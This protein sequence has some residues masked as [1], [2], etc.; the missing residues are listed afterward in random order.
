MTCENSIGSLCTGA[1]QLDVAVRSLLGGTS[2]WHAEVEPNAARVLEHRF[3][4]VPNLGDMTKLTDTPPVRILALG[5][6][7]QP[8]SSA[9][10]Q[11]FDSD[12]RWLWPHALRVITINRPPIVVFENVAGLVTGRKGEPW[13]AILADWRAAGYLIKW[14]LLGA[15]AIGAAHCRHR[16]FA[17]GV[18]VGVDIA[19]DPIRLDVKTCGKRSARYLPS[20][21]AN[22]GK[23][24]VALWKSRDYPQ[25]LRTAV[26]MLPSP[27]AR[28]GRG[29]GSPEYWAERSE[30]TGRTNGV[31]LGAALR[32]LATPRA[33]D[34]TVQPQHWGRYAEAIARQAAWFGEPPAPTEPNRNGAPR[35]RAE[36]AEWLM[37]WPAGWVTDILPRS[38]ALVRI[39]NG[40][41]PQQAIA[42]LRILLSS[43]A[44]AVPRVL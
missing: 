42:A 32:L 22:D 11:G 13:R 24:G 25:D 26:A 3:P 29:E 21:T 44:C 28:D 18:Y 4:G 5:V 43:I 34:G 31:P 15:C 17:L 7:C 30:Q 40:V 36:F 19:P 41:M 33:T 12:S 35:L 8:A 20:P 2:A 14:L 1:G 37:G 6:P 9:G 39:G 27:A 38:P 10:R 16:V 23:A